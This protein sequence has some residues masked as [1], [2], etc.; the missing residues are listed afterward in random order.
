[1]IKPDA[2]ALNRGA[3]ILCKSKE[4]SFRV[5]FIRTS[6]AE[7]SLGSVLELRELIVAI[8]AIKV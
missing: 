6:V 2:E 7:E 8:F 3:L 1:M 4:I 5:A